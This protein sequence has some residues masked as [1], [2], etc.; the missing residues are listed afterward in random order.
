MIDSTGSLRGKRRWNPCTCVR[1]WPWPERGAPLP[2][3]E[4]E[5]VVDRKFMADGF[6]LLSDTGAERREWR[7]TWAEAGTGEWKF[8]RAAVCKGTGHRLRAV[9]RLAL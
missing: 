9:W 7:G 4:G 5:R 6:W 1:D 3:V 2:A 8:G